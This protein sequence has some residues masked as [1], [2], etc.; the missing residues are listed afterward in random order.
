ML[1]VL[2]SRPTF[3]KRKVSLTMSTRGLLEFPAAS[4]AATGAPPPRHKVGPCDLGDACS[5]K[6][7]EL[8]PE[9]RCR[10][11]NKQL[12]G[13]ISGCS[14]A[15]N[16][17]DFR[18]GVICKNQPCVVAAAPPAARVSRREAPAPKAPKKKD[19]VVCCY[20]L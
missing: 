18:D 10:H 9:Y 17:K 19:G 12:H 11:C 16:E 4:F 15:K 5:A 13:F 2:T 7:T 6:D 3:D 14:K 1:T 8:L 20:V